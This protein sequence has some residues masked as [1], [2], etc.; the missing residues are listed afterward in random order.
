MDVGFLLRL[1][2]AKAAHSTPTAR[3]KLPAGQGGCASRALTW[4]L[5]ESQGLTKLSQN[6]SNP[7]SSKHDPSGPQSN[8]KIHK[9]YILAVWVVLPNSWSFPR[10]QGQRAEQPEYSGFSKIQVCVNIYIFDRSD[11]FYLSS[12][13]PQEL[14]EA[15]MMVECQASFLSIFV[16]HQWLGKAHPDRTGAGAGR[17]GM[18]FIT[19]RWAPSHS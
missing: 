9:V 17:E 3:N 10:K 16:S 7:G 1:T 8:M 6:S 5:R 2:S 19:T 14:R 4:K 13:A 15:K 12:F 11:F 18:M